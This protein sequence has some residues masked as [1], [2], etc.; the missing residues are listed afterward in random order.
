M[1]RLLFVLGTTVLVL[2]SLAAATGHADMIQW[3]ASTT[4]VGPYAQESGT[5]QNVTSF[6]TGQAWLT[7]GSSWQPTTGTNSQSLILANIWANDQSDNGLTKTFGGSQ[8]NYSLSL[9][10]RDIAS[11]ASGTLTFQG[12][13]GGSF[14]GGT[15]GITNAFLGSTTQSLTLGKNVYTVTIG[16]FVPP[17]GWGDPPYSQEPPGSISASIS[18]QPVTSATPEPSSLLLACLAVP[19]LGL[20]RWLRRRKS[21]A[22]HA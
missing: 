5:S 6:Q 7:I 14:D 15:M 8:A 9:D 10:L 11:G 1:K 12:Q 20:A 4:L 13:L 18:V 3:S 22:N 2:S 19:P 21:V 16:P 17:P